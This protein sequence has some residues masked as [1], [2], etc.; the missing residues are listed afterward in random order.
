MP[1]PTLRPPS[2]PETAPGICFGD[3]QEAWFWTIGALRARRE[4]AGRAGPGT[5]R[6]CEPDD[7]IR[8]VDRLWRDERLAPAHLRVLRVCGERGH[9]PVPH[10]PAEQ[11]AARLWT[12]AMT[13]LG[14]ALHAKGI[15]E[16][17]MIASNE[18]CKKNFLDMICRPA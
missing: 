10:R 1:L 13:Q 8:A 15:V 18:N 16:R 7:V 3:A 5:P 2:L 11:Q 14:P 4:G 17:P 12:E 9:A 6:P